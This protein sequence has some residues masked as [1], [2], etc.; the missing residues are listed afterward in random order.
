MKSSVR[1]AG[2]AAVSE[3]RKE[4]HYG[5]DLKSLSTDFRE[6]VDRRDSSYWERQRVNYETRYCLWNNQSWDGRKWRRTDSKRV[7]P[8]PGAS[9]ARVML[10][11]QYINADVAMLMGVWTTQ[12]ILVKSTAPHKTADDAFRMTQLLR[13]QL[14]EDMEESEAEAE[15]LANLFLERGAAA[16]GVFWDQQHQLTRETITLEELQRGSMAAQIALNRGAASDALSLQAQLPALIMDPE[17]DGEVAAILGELLARTGEPEVMDAARIRKILRDLR[18]TGEAK[19]P[20]AT[21][22]RDRPTIRTLAW[23]EDVF[24]PPECADPARARVQF[25]REVLTE[26]DLEERTRSLGYDA[27]WVDEV[28]ESQRGVMAFQPSERAASRARTW[29]RGRPETTRLFEVVSSYRR[30]YDEDGIPGIWVTVFSPGLS[31][32]ARRRDPEAVAKHELLDYT[33]GQYPIVPFA[34]LR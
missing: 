28:I 1:P 27:A 26:T 12:R 8:W 25:V 4:R 23:N 15:Y 10:A 18:K 7:F 30:M 34:G 6:C 16:V 33:H 17:R 29:G 21:V 3:D 20:R 24:L 19:F 14:Y 31:Q 5:P 22:V 11:D 2:R 32:S 9:D 13:W